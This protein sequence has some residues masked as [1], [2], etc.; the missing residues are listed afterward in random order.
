MSHHIDYAAGLLTSDLWPSLQMPRLVQRLDGHQPAGGH[1]L[2]EQ[3]DSHL[4][5]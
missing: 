4:C 5:T 1:G 3:A 2:D